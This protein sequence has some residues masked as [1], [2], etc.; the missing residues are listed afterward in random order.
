M[1]TDIFRL[2]RN[3]FA[4]DYTDEHRCCEI[5]SRVHPCHPRLNDQSG[6][7]GKIVFRFP[8]KAELWKSVAKNA[9]QSEGSLA[10]ICCLLILYELPE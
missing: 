1:N 5:I 3:L 2:R 8:P 7:R 10:Y 4:T 9:E 6:R